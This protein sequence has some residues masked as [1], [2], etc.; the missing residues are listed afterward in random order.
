[1]AVILTSGTLQPIPAAS[2]QQIMR[3]LPLMNPS[4]QSFFASSEMPDEKA[5]T[6][7]RRWAGSADLTVLTPF[8]QAISE[9]K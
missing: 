6:Q 5:Y 1:M 9:S 3:Y 8:P 7:S 4:Q 2:V